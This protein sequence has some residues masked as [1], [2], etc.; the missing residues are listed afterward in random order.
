MQIVSMLFNGTGTPT[1]SEGAILVQDD[2]TEMYGYIDRFGKVI[3]PYQYYEANSFSDGLALVKNAKRQYEYVDKTGKV[4]I[5]ASQYTSGSNFSEGLAAVA[6]RDNGQSVAKFGYIDTKGNMKIEP[7]F[8]KAYGF[9]EGLAKVCVGESIN[10][11][12]IGYIDE[13][14]AYK[15]APNLN[16]HY[17]DTLFSEGLVPIAD[18]AGGY[19][20]KEGQLVVNPVIPKDDENYIKHNIAGEFRNGIAK[21]SFTDG[22]IGYIDKSGTYIWDPRN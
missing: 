9:S 11:Y 12:S 19:V 4:M 13:S 2:K 3:L 22:K 8:A 15:V 5:D 14:G 17:D 7:K 1:Q 6:V 21:V 10:A 16:D 18:G 20:N